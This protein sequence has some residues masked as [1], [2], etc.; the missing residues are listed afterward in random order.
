MLLVRHGE[1]APFRDGQP[2]ALV[3]GH[4]DPPLDPVGVEQAERVGSRLAGEDIAA[5]YVTNLQRTAQTAA[6]LAA[7]LELQPIVEPDLREVFLG[8]WEGGVFR[9]YVTEQ[10]EIAMQLQTEQRWDV[11]P[12]AEPGDAFRSRVV[13]AIGRIAERHADQFVVVVTHGGVIAQAIAYA[14]GARLFSFMCDNASISHLV[15][16]EGRWLVR[17]YN[18]TSHL[19][20]GFTT[21]PEPMM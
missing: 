2:F 13:S 21:A 15:V 8:E 19:H 16:H 10:S 9:K 17:R 5:I 11:I 20:P 14:T 18:D 12:G 4:G 1:S 7:R 3:D 6:P